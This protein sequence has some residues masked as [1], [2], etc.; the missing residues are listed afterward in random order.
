[1]T[2][3]S[4]TD[5]LAQSKEQDTNL[6]K[7]HILFSY[8]NQ[9]ISLSD[10]IETSHPLF[11][12]LRVDKKPETEGELSGALYV[13]YRGVRDL[14][15]HN[16]HGYAWKEFLDSLFLIVK[17]ARACGHEAHLNIGGG[18][19]FP[20]MEAIIGHVKVERKTAR[21]V[22]RAKWELRKKEQQKQNPLTQTAQ[23]PQNTNNPQNG[24]GAAPF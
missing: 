6:E 24:G 4:F 19:G 21:E 18:L 14:D 3:K 11:H 10:I 7:N 12:C 1:M 22:S 5:L 23:D 8:N 16:P 17:T 20:I 15:D 2:L 13:S 9:D